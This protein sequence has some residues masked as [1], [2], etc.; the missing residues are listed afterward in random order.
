[1]STFYSIKIY[2]ST[3]DDLTFY[4]ETDHPSCI[5]IDNKIYPFTFNTERGF[6]YHRV[7]L[8]GITYDITYIISNYN[9]RI[10]ANK[11]TKILK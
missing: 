6:H 9:N 11:N 1:M 5:M 3:Y 2:N 10:I 8:F 4:T 7:E